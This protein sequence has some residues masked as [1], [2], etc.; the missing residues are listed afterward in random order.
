MNK[1]DDIIYEDDHFTDD[2]YIFLN[3]SRQ[4]QEHLNEIMQLCDW[5]AIDLMNIL[6]VSKST[7]N[8][9]LGNDSM[10]NSKPTP[11]HKTDLITLL[12]CIQQKKIKYTHSLLVFYLF[13]ILC[14]GMP[15]TLDFE[16]FKKLSVLEKDLP[17]DLLLQ[18][19]NCLCPDTIRSFNRFIEWRLNKPDV[20]IT[21]YYGHPEL[22]EYIQL[23]FDDNEPM[24]TEIKKSLEY[25]EKFIPL[26]LDWYI[27][28]IC[29]WCR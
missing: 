10:T 22:N 26:Y 13:S 20:T 21:E 27:S 25:S 1:F 14:P 24:E 7:C 15:V 11:I 16:P 6:S 5:R 8:N 28:K 3:P 18:N 19:L 29:K 9:I 12:M 17:P 4:F 23:E 2:D